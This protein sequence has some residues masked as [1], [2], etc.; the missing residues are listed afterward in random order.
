MNTFYDCTN[1]NFNQKKIE[2][3]NRMKR[4]R[5]KQK[6]EQKMTEKIRFD[7]TQNEKIVKRKKLFDKDLITMIKQKR[8]TISS[9]LSV[10]T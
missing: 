10:R 3:L 9:Q 8:T 5:K 7:E 4:V 6:Q 1:L 2:Q